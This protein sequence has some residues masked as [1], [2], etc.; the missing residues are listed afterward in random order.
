ML[1]A[2]TLMVV[3]VTIICLTIAAIPRIGRIVA[4]PH[5]SNWNADSITPE[6]VGGHVE[7][8]EALPIRTS[9]T[10]R[11]RSL[12]SRMAGPLSQEPEA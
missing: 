5:W 9:E 2:F 8:I 11:E 12:A 1:R 6:R 10:S 7:P 3:T 4:P